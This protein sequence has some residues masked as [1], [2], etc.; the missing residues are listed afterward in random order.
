MPRARTVTDETPKMER[1]T[2]AQP[3]EV[4]GELRTDRLRP[5]D[6]PALLAF[7]QDLSPMVVRA[8]RPYGPN[9]TEEALRDGPLARMAAGK[10]HAM[11]L[12]DEAGAIWGHAF[13]QEFEPRKYTFGLGVHERL[14]GR[15]LGRRLMA[16]LLDAAEEEPDVT[17]IDLTCI[18]DNTAAVQL[19]RS[20]GF[21][22]VAEFVSEHDGLP[23]CQMIK[24]AAADG[25]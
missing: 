13:L 25:G 18:R 21:E 3:A 23:Y 1:R 9:V 20:M 12:R 4:A 15:G 17:L 5:D 14:L 6:L 10:E 7:Y 2:D 16:A 22:I 19:Y 24:A 11:V 8:F